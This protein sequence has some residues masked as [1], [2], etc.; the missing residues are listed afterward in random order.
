[1]L[2]WTLSSPSCLQLVDDEQAHADVAHQDLHR[3]LGVLVLEQQLHPVLARTS[4]A[5]SAMPSISQ[6]HESAYGVWNG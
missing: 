4:L 3:G 6:R 5:A 2:T 1:M